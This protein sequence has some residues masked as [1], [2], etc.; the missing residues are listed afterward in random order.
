MSAKLSDSLS[1][2]FRNAAR[3]K[4]LSQFQRDEHGKIGPEVETI[5]KLWH[6]NASQCRLVG[7]DGA[8]PVAGQS[9]HA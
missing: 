2:F 7:A 3:V 6:A 1:G 8:P 4:V 9:R 5:R